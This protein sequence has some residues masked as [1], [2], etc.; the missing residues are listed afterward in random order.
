MILVL[1][2][3]LLLVAIV[4]IAT[5]MKA[6]RA[7]QNINFILEHLHITREELDKWKMYR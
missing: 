1:A 3:Y 6:A 4:L 2:F 5:S 7:E